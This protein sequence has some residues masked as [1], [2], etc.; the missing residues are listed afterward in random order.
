MDD[1]CPKSLVPANG[2]NKVA[3]SSEG[4]AGRIVI[5]PGTHLQEAAS[6]ASLESR[7]WESAQGASP[8]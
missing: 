8:T 5:V 7:R 1:F 4:P 6:A 2:V 3:G